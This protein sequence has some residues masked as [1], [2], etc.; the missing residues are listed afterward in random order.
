MTEAAVR[1]SRKERGM[2]LRERPSSA[3][4]AVFGGNDFVGAKVRVTANETR[5]R[6][7]EKPSQI[8]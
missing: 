8:I 2:L 7:T 1:F 4:S 6:E 5:A 3:Q